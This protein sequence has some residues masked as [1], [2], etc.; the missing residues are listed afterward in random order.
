LLKH[1]LPD[2]GMGF[3]LVQ[4]LDPVHDSALAQLLGRATPLPVHEV[5]KW[6]A[7]RNSSEATTRNSGQ[8]SSRARRRQVRGSR[9]T[10]SVEQR[11]QGG[12]P[13]M[14]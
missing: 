13:L 11:T 4:H 9:M 1:L 14:S 7:A 5:T 6:N 2:T 12:P 8:T 3:V 10:E